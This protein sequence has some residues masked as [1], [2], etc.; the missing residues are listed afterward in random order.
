MTTTVVR[1]GR[2]LDVA[3]HR[4]EPADVLIEGDTIGEIGRPGLPAP[5]GAVV[6]D[7]RDRLLV[8]GLVNAHTHGHGALAR[9]LVGDRV[10]LELLLTIGGAAGSN[11]T[12][13][14]KYLSAQL[15][16][17]EM[18]RRGCTA[19]YD[20]YVEYPLPTV[21]GLHAAAR[22]YADVG[23]RAVLAPMMADRT[24]YQ[25]L[26]GLLDA[27]P[28]TA[29][30][31]VEAWQASPWETSLAVCRELLATWPFDRDR[32]RPALGPT[33]P[34]HCSDAFLVACR[35]LAR[36]YDVSV[37]THLAESKTQAVLGRQK[38][39]TTLTAHLADLGLLGPRFSGAHGVWLDRDDVRRLADAGAS[40]AH[41][42][43]SNLRLGSGIAPVRM[44]LEAGLAVGV[45]TDS[46]S[47]S[48]TQNMFECTRLAAYLSRVR[49]P[50]Y[51]R[52][53]T[54]EEA[55]GMATEG[56]AG[57]L[58]MAGRIG[59]LAPG[60]QAD[61]VFLDLGHPGYVPLNDVAVQLVMGE[62]GAAVDSVMIAGR[63]V[64]D[65][66]RL[67]TVDEAK[68]RAQAEAA[69]ARLTAANA[70]A[71]ATARALQPFVGAFCVAMA[72][73]PYDLDTREVR[74]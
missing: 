69:R 37:Q 49:T 65:R 58:G 10:P 16:A 1:G 57:V 50:D 12:L 44:M 19:C 9:G 4:A 64:L 56:S 18:V 34:L 26:P 67:L 71:L 66:G 51:E 32:V 41:N 29:R 68:L 21:E 39:G 3:G 48:D 55:L 63:L 52:W 38:Y 35:D 11:R 46:A 45:G 27:L 24:L 23:I 72:S 14:D 47:S 59:R 17:V 7:A 6:V 40:V 25:A 31:R 20:L 73:R 8:P 28:D 30:R 2:V 62:S 36:E 61:I 74:L 22:A 54:V 70:E 5:A 15:A 33:I 13:D 42:P 53:V 60:F 43:L